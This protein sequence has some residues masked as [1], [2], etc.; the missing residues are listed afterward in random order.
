MKM[1]PSRMFL[2]DFFN[3]T[4]KPVAFDKMMKCD[5]SEIDNNYVI[6]MDM[7]G[8]KKDE[9]SMEIDKG[10][11][12]VSYESKNDTEENSDKKYIRRERHVYTNC[13][14]QFYVGDIDEEAIKASF[15]DGILTVTV[16]K[17][18]EKETKK[19]ISID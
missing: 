9:I 12:T 15:K 17:K 6:E 14:R 8:V 5:I 13:S 1:L 16:P 2:D 7:P 3:D 18:E 4:D 19:I 11:L 10:Y